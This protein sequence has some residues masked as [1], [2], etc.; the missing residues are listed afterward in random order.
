MSKIVPIILCGG[1][2]TR[3]WPR[4]RPTKPKP[5]LHLLGKHTPFEE[6]LL[7]VADSELFASPIIVV[8][9][10]HLESAVQQAAKIAHAA[11]FVVEPVSRNTA[12][13]VA[14][15]AHRLKPDDIMLVCPSDH[16]IEDVAAFHEA[17]SRAARLAQSGQLV[18]FGIEAKYPETG[19]GYLCRGPAYSSGHKINAFVEKPNKERASEFLARGNYAWNGG[20][21]AFQ[22]GV[23]LAELKRYRPKIARGIVAAMASGIEE[24]AKFVPDPLGFAAIEGDS[25]DYAVMEQ[26]D[27][28]AMVDV[29]MGWSDIGNWDALKRLRRSEADINGNVRKGNGEFFDSSNSMI[30]TDG[31][32]V[33]V[34]GL[35]NVIVAVEGS[36][37]LVTHR[38][39]AHK[40][41][42]LAKKFGS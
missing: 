14:L 20:I 5:F 9:M 33:A 15:A 1:G 28:A 36:E 39:S 40:V 4:S 25:I 32:T 30:D 10:G 21:F 24:N 23:F 31:P 8:G 42:A 13:A 34:L 22:A 2:G 16:H 29:D 11:R 19:Y 38:D 3:L 6:S 12:P 37:I 41:G 7:R 26:T 18:A 17:I 27:L 35:D